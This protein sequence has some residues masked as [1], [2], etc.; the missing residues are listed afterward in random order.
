MKI[1][2]NCKSSIEDASVFCV[3]CGASVAAPQE[4]QQPAP[5]YAQH[6]PPQGAQQV[7]P[8]G[9]QQVPPQ[10]VPY[11]TSTTVPPV[12]PFDHTSEFD[13]QDIAD[14]KLLAMLVYLL[15]IAGVLVALLA[16]KESAYL[17]FHV[18]QGV[19]F[20]IVETLVSL[21]T[22][23]LCWTCIAPAVGGVFLVALAVVQLICFF[24]VCNGKAKEAA[25]IRS[26]KFLD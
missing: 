6:V 17:D 1:C 8:Q 25:I 13:A 12:D 2:P 9:T 15:G 18:R 16:K 7:P 24:D 5:E 22:A 23:L 3:V 19:K 14:N 21:A 26:F 20:V 11:Y 4:A 10:G